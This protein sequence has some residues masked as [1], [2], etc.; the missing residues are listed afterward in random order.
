MNKL[1]AAAVTL[2][3]AGISTSAFAESLT[4][5]FA[6]TVTQITD[7]VEPGSNGGAI[8]GAAG[9][10]QGSTINVSV[11]VDTSANKMGAP[12]IQGLNISVT[13][14]WD[15]NSWLGTWTEGGN[16]VLQGGG[17]LGGPLLT[18]NSIE[19]PSG[20]THWNVNL[21]VVPS[22]GALA[23]G[24][25]VEIHVDNSVHAS[26]NAVYTGK[27]ASTPELDPSSGAAAL[28]LLLGGS[29]LVFSSRS[30]R[31]SSRC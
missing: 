15:N 21:N 31:Q 14:P 28:A 26:L 6:M 24:S 20:S 17:G 27:P 12:Q 16:T 10:T 22:S 8:F 19:V 3:A 7:A 1:V 18:V 11:N 23:I 2:F 9:I 13:N 29:T 30:R 4:Y 5:N 25:S